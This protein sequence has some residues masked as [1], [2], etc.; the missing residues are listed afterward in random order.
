M[1]ML[2]QYSNNDEV[3]VCAKKNEKKMLKQYFE[4]GGRDVVDYDRE[5]CEVVNVSCGM[6]VSP[7][8]L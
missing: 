3:I 5:E 1:K 8:N 2:V 6:Q 7:D 4:E